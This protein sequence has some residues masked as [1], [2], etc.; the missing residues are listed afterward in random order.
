MGAMAILAFMLMHLL[1]HHFILDIHFA[2]LFLFGKNNFQ[3]HTKT[4]LLRGLLGNR[5]YGCYF[6]ILF[7]YT[8]FH[9]KISAPKLQ[10][11]TF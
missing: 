10:I 6:V 1:L 8:F 7:A 5:M 2:S 11:Y 9:V 4:A 3:P